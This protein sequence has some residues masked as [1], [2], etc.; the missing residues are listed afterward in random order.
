MFL[1]IKVILLNLDFFDF[2][3][4]YLLMIVIIHVLVTLPIFLIP[5]VLGKVYLVIIR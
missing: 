5:E 1:L 4:V 2:D 3:V